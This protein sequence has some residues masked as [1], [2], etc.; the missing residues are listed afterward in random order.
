MQPELHRFFLAWGLVLFF[1]VHGTLLMTYA[2]H[3]FE[4]KLKTGKGEIKIH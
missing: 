2:H 3:V 4:D 1:L